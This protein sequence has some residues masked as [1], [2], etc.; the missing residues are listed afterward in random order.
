MKKTELCIPSRCTA[1]LPDVLD[2]PWYVAEEKLDGSRYVFYI[3]GDPY[4][5]R[6]SNALLSRRVSVVDG[7]HVDRTDNVPHITHVEYEGLEGTILDG[8]IMAADFLSTNS[9]M[10]SGPSLAVSK[11]N[12]IGPCKYYVFDVMFFRGKDVRTLPLSQ[13]RKV[14]EEVVKRMNNEHVVA[15]PQ[16]TSDLEGYFREIVN[17][18]GE[19]VII[20]DLRSAYGV[21]WCKMKKSYDVSCVIS[22]FKP[23]NGKYADSLGSIAVSVYHA[24]R[25]VE[26][27]FA[28]GFDDKVRSDMA[29][30][31]EKYR[32]MVVDVFAQEIQASKRSSDNPVGRLRHPTF[33]RFRDDL[34]AQDCTSEKLWS[35]LK[36]A[37]ARNRRS[38]FDE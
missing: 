14:L 8:E 1:T 7:K 29:K 5:R 17:D 34:N 24:K 21:G 16:I 6:S 19:G 20:K 11:Q 22:G 37:K 36:A 15:I 28:S 13:R 10:N 31:F 25:L 38:K 35:D 12:E 4:E 3:A 18:G 33:F 2:K 30:N 26:I 27:G 23:G 32:G 9:I